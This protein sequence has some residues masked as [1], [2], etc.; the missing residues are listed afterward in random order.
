MYVQLDYW[1]EADEISQID[2]WGQRVI[3]LNVEVSGV[4][5]FE[6]F[7]PMYSAS[8]YCFPINLSIVHVLF[9]FSSK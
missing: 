9:L 7:L 6:I 1:I 3:W 2:G 5:S 8:N 4:L